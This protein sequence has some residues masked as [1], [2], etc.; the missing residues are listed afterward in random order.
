M[1]GTCPAGGSENDG[2][3]KGRAREASGRNAFGCVASVLAVGRE[4]AARRGS[5]S[6][7][8]AA[9]LAKASNKQ[10]EKAPRPFG[11]RRFGA[12][13]ECCAPLV[14]TG[15][16]A[17]TTTWGLTAS[18]AVARCAVPGSNAG[19][20]PFASLGTET[21]TES[22][23][24]VPG[25]VTATARKS[26]AA[27]GGTSEGASGEKASATGASE[28]AVAAAGSGRRFFNGGKIGVS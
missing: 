10:L 4:D 14:A 9:A 3:E 22:S 8:N 20:C 24:G 18:D 11:T 27:S 19:S 7:R 5:D 16:L 2:A 26:G 1:N 23:E 28:L 6:Q 15:W 13:F 12:S 25:A 17:G 21:G